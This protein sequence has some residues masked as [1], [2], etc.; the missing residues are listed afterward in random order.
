MLV[1]SKKGVSKAKRLNFICKKGRVD[2]KA[3]QF[4]GLDLLKKKNNLT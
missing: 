1:V 4:C 3:M 2:W